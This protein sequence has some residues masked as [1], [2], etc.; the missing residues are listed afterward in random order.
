MGDNSFSMQNQQLFIQFIL[1]KKKK[2]NYYSIYGSEGKKEEVIDNI[3][4]M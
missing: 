1:S 2:K 4:L 3:A